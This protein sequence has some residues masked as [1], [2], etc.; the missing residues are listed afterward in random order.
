M[1]GKVS[2]DGKHRR[3]ADNWPSGHSMY[4]DVLCDGVDKPSPSPC[5]PTSS[6]LLS[7][8]SSQDPSLND[9][10]E[11]D[12]KREKQDQSRPY[13][14]AS[15]SDE[16]SASTP[17]DTSS[18]TP[19]ARASRLFRQRRKEREKILRETIAELAERN[20]A[21]ETLLLRHGIV[22][23]HT[24]TLR[25]ELSIHRSQRLGGPPI[26]IPGVTTIRPKRSS[27]MI[28]AQDDVSN[29]HAQRPREPMPAPS[30]L[31]RTFL[32]H[33]LPGGVAPHT[34][35]GHHHINAPIQDGYHPFV[36]SSQGTCPPA[37]TFD[38]LLHI[39]APCSSSGVSTQAV[40]NLRQGDAL[41]IPPH[42]RHP[43]SQ[44]HF[45]SSD[46]GCLG[47]VFSWEH[48]QAHS[49]PDPVSPP[50][51]GRS[52]LPYGG[53]QHL[54]EMQKRGPAHTHTRSPSDSALLSR[55]LA[56][57]L[58]EPRAI[59][60]G[61]GTT[62]ALMSGHAMSGQVHTPHEVS[63]LCQPFPPRLHAVPSWVHHPNPP[64]HHQ[65]ARLFL[66]GTSVSVGANTMA[67]PIETFASPP[68]CD[69]P[70]PGSTASGSVLCPHE[71]TGP[72]LPPPPGLSSFG[73]S[74]TAP[75]SEQQTI[76][77][78]SAPSVQS[79]PHPERAQ[80]PASFPLF[81]PMPTPGQ[82]SSTPD[83]RPPQPGQRP[84]IAHS[85]IEGDKALRH[86]DRP[87]VRSPSAAGSPLTPEGS[88]TGESSPRRRNR[89][90]TLPDPRSISHANSI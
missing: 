63:D 82:A 29:T 20:V 64:D 75:S 58:A 87:F 12:I 15:P 89:A 60:A 36:R 17:I 44:G 4:S 53:F 37:Q 84:Y 59:A 52:T 39:H 11:R 73:G 69:P 25:N 86:G 7:D 71:D 76:P 83:S 6:S 38:E 88:Q 62:G 43:H 51:S 34:N 56:L 10:V 47:S 27:G 21:L 40:Q 13:Q 30:V 41:P 54:L 9:P 48:L 31:K 18:N 22:P 67:L 32:E 74:N 85:V 2:D 57:S 49:I 1:T 81:P 66:P 79:F 72:Y 5:E 26:H 78:G 90:M 16:N 55:N 70:N 24:A 3:Q 28:G 68:R 23:P 42:L 35:P 65:D 8:G 77:S 19:N 46:R 61:G 45:G 50:N 33:S 14:D 80:M